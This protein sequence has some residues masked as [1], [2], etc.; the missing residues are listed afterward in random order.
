MTERWHRTLDLVGLPG[1]PKDQRPI[2]YHG[3]GRGWIFREVPWGKRKIKEWLES[4]LPNETQEALRQARGDDGG[5]ASGACSSPKDAPAPEGGTVQPGSSS[6]GSG[7]PPSGIPLTADTGPVAVMDARAEI[8]RA[9]R[10]WHGTI[11]AF[12]ESYNSGETQVS[13]ETR[14]AVA[15]VSARTLQRWAKSRQVA[16]VAALMP[17]RGGRRGGI[18]TAPEVRG[19]VESM[20]IA[21]PYHVTARHII[22]AVEARWPG[23][24]PPSISTMHRFAKRWRAENGFDI[25]ATSD[26]DGHLSRTKP[27]FGKKAHEVTALNELWELDST[28]LDIICADGRR[29]DVVVAFDVWSRRAKATVTPRSNSFAIGTLIRRGL[30]DWG[31]PGMVRTDEG[32]DYTSKHLARVLAD[33]RVDHE[34]LPPFSP[35]LKPFVERFI[36]TMS[37][38]LLTQ[39]PGFAG[40]NVADAARIRAKK[41][42]AERYGDPDGKKKRFFDTALSAEELQERIDLWIE[43][44]YNRRPHSGLDGISPFERAVSWTGERKTVDERGLDILLAPA[45]GDGRRKVGKGGIRVGSGEYIAGELGSHM[46]EWTHV[47]QD[48]ADWGRIYVFT[49]PDADGVHHFICIAEDPARTGIDREEVANAANRNWRERN[50]QA[51]ARARKLEREHRPEDTMDE[52]L[53]AAKTDA[54]TV[55]P[56][57]QK[58]VE[59]RTGALD[60]AAEAEEA[61]AA[62]EDR[63]RRRL[64][65]VELIKQL[66]GGENIA[67][68]N[69]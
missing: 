33:L 17:G 24:E 3:P 40:H 13:T 25:S 8:V 52:V 56:F 5:R 12:A 50:K 49:E 55:L 4:S 6:Q 48:P 32:K 2:R 34:I 62:L 19:L 60:A 21:N 31:V 51:R 36:G 59:H 10:G 9:L 38:G 20:L 68:L 30:V 37:R 26:P 66:Y 61:G 58:T 23:L 1:M 54:E 7:A 15:T 63:E 43:N 69:R 64:S 29:H 47:R 11:G 18:D 28:K 44:K 39:L 46:G 27:A 16:G 45:A 42:F 53:G 41:S 57:P 35:W 14:A 67:D 22:E 65:E